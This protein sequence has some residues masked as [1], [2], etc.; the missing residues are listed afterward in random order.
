MLPG[1]PEGVTSLAAI[2]PFLNPRLEARIVNPGHLDVDPLSAVIMS[3]HPT[4][5]V[6]TILRKGNTTARSRTAVL[7]NLAVGLSL[8]RSQLF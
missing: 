1:D 2:L 5:V 7:C 4:S 6:C 3:R 8:Q